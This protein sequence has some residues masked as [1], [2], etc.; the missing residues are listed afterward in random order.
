MATCINWKSVAL[1]GTVIKY[2]AVAMVVPLITSLVY[3]E[4][5]LVFLASMAI[6]VG[7]GFGLE[8]LEDDDSLGP[9]EAMLFV[10]LA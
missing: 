6:A 10:T 4:D 5:T 1:T 3:G 9:P 7:V 8:Q 2:L